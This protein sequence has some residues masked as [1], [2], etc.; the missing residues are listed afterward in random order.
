LK[1]SDDEP[2]VVTD[3]GLKPAVTPDGRPE[4]ASEMG[5]ATPE[6]IAVETLVEPEVPAVTGTAAGLAHVTSRSP[7]HSELQ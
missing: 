2:P 1:V 6:T 3:A 4:A 5:C 7:S